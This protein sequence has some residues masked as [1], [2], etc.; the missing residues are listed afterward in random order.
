MPGKTHWADF[1]QNWGIST[2]PRSNHPSKFDRDI[3]TGYWS[4]GVQSLGPRIYCIHRSYKQSPAIAGASD[5]LCACEQK[6]D[7]IFN[8]VQIG[9]VEADEIYKVYIQ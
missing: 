7:W 2:S 3:L 8:F 4:A 9:Y 5:L 1:Y 6:Y